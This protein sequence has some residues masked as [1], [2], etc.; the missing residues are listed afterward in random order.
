MCVW[1]IGTLTSQQNVAPHTVATVGRTPTWT[2]H[3][4]FNTRWKDKYTH[5]VPSL[6]RSHSGGCCCCCFACRRRR[7]HPP[8]RPFIR[9]NWESLRMEVV[10]K[11]M[12]VV[13][14]AQNE[15]AYTLKGEIPWMN[16]VCRICVR[17]I[18]RISRCHEWKIYNS[19]KVFKC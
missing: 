15:R 18:Y 5:H 14:M 13:R 10:Y 12:Y 17:I 2:T 4:A 7:H 1:F 8:V 16:F 11:P 9:S 19:T 6:F 3:I